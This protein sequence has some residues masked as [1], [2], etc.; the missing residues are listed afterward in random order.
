MATYV[1]SDVH[2]HADALEAALD[3]CALGPDDELF[4]LGDLVDRGPE[5][6]RCLQLVRD[7]PSIHVLKGNHEAM[8][9]DAMDHPD[10]LMA[11][12]QW[13]LNGGVITVCQLDAMAEDQARDLL[14][15][16]RDLPLW[17]T[18]MVGGRCFGLVHAGIDPKTVA[19]PMGAADEQGLGELL[20]SQD[21]ETLLW[22]RQGFWDE[23]TGLLD[24]EGAGPLIVAGHTPTPYVRP[25]LMGGTDEPDV[26]G[27]TP[28][29][30]GGMTEETAGHPD[31]VDIDCACA[32]GYPMGQ[33]A[34]LR[35]DDGE[36]RYFPV[37]KG[38]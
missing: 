11:Q 12:Q 26:E 9:L 6:I 25:M 10:S 4:V 21:E 18:A 19:G 38:Q 24:G 5:P 8:M 14:Q 34:L 3:A 23:P 22:V 16:V 1:L 31:K 28:I 13:A 29:L 37:A 33:L 36:V 7:V 2:G 20:A 30:W 15:W 17:A 27:R 32:G 35:L